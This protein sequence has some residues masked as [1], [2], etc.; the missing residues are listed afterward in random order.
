MS[1]SRVL[2]LEADAERAD[3]LGTL[4]DF[5]D[6]RPRLC[7]S[8]KETVS[9]APSDYIA[10][11]IGKAEADEIRQVTRWLAQ[12]PLHPPVLVLPPNTA[13]FAERQGLE[14]ETCWNL[15]YPLRCPQLSEILQS[16]SVM[17]IEQE[18]AMSRMVGPTGHSPKAEALRNMIKQVAAYDTTVLILGESG[19]GKEVVARAVHDASPRA[20]KPFVAINC[21]AIPSELLESEL[22]GHEKGA[23]TGAINS[24][25]GRF[26]LAEGGTIFLDEIGDMSLHMQVKLLRVIQERVF[27]RVGGNRS[28]ECDV[29]IIAATHR[30]LESR[31]AEGEFREDLFYRLNVFP[32]DMPPLRE[33]REDIPQL[34]EELSANLAHSPAGRRRTGLQFSEKALQALRQ[35]TWPGNV[36]ELAN[37]IERLS[38][39][40]PKGRIDYKDLPERYRGPETD[41]QVSAEAEE[42]NTGAQISGESVESPTSS[43]DFLPDAGINLRHH[44]AD[45]EKTLITQALDRTEGVVAHAAQLLGLRRTTLVEKLRKY[46]MQADR[47]AA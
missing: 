32:I 40:N 3:M 15:E 33:R 26:E 7:T 30:D 11:M 1:E 24:R 6:L 16:A 45:I 2:I 31:I 21:G 17:R 44:I 28:I 12:D 27:E 10:V 25:A 42:Q 38:V 4:V 5:L 9:Q 43:D 18:E 13:E 20:N 29:R 14:P 37:L 35:Y 22:F 47:S 19:T 46:D 8:V 41:I 36:R 39:M 34:I 23:F